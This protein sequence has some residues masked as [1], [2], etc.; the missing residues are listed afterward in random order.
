MKKV[1]PLWSHNI[2]VSIYCG[3]IYAPTHLLALEPRT[4]VV[5]S[6]SL[7]GSH[8][9]TNKGYYKF[10]CIHPS[11]IRYGRTSTNV[12]RQTECIIITNYCNDMC[13]EGKKMKTKSGFWEQFLWLLLHRQ[14]EVVAG[15]LKSCYIFRDPF[16][17][18]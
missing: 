1:R 10:I 14:S 17:L 16:Q 8:W 9:N 6:E 12:F 18:K 11:G 13:T 7:D 4:K 5:V 2:N 3:V 15:C